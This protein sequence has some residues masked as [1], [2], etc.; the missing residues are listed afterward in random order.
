MQLQMLEE[1]DDDRYIKYEPIEEFRI[2]NVVADKE[3]NSKEETKQEDK[4]EDES[5][6]VFNKGDI[7]KISF[8]EKETPNILLE[9]KWMV[10]E[11]SDK[12]LNLQLIEEKE[13]KEKFFINEI[14]EFTGNIH[15]SSAYKSDG[16]KCNHGK[17]K[18]TNICKKQGA[19][20]YYHII[21]V[22]GSS[23][24]VWGWVD[25]KDLKKI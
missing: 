23:S 1:Q 24:T 10:N 11:S 17:A 2:F 20:H 12:L 25:E 22:E 6:F 9:K 5:F 19:L 21:R 16:Y 3:E 7:L 8:A 4:K 13:E 15:Y 14:V 18:I